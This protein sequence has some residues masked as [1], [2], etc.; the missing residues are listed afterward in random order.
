MWQQAEA[1]SVATYTQRIQQ[2]TSSLLVL[3]TGLNRRAWLAWMYWPLVRAATERMVVL[4]EALRQRPRF[5]RYLSPPTVVSRDIF[6]HAKLASSTISDLCSQQGR[7]DLLD[8]EQFVKSPVLRNATSRETCASLF[9]SRV[10]GRDVQHRKSM[11][12]IEPRS[13]WYPRRVSQMRQSRRISH[14]YLLYL[15]Y[16]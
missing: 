9:M 15:S 2:S 8:G 10:K 13:C 3:L 5:P 16:P 6:L 11:L 4:A 12:A 7:R 1:S 14:N